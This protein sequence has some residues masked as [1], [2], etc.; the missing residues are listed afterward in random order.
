MTANQIVDIVLKDLETSPDMSGM[1]FCEK[2]FCIGVY[3][4]YRMYTMGLI[5]QEIG[6]KLK[7]ELIMEF[8]H[9][10]MF[11]DMYLKN[12][13]ERQNA[14]ALGVKLTKMLKANENDSE[15][16]DVALKTLNAS[17]L[18]GGIPWRKEM[19]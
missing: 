11:E 6:K 14:V 8:E 10:Q 7:K 17:G 5:N 16:L 1:T 4:I 13:K 18:S 9:W 12:I 3:R 15:I 2:V 19:Q